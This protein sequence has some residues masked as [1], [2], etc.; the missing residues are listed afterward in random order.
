MQADAGESRQGEGEDMG[1]QEHTRIAL[2][3]TPQSYI[4]A[5]HSRAKAVAQ[6]G[7]SHPEARKHP[8]ELIQCSHACSSTGR[9]GTPVLLLWQALIIGRKCRTA[10]QVPQDAKAGKESPLSSYPACSLSKCELGCPALVLHSSQQ[11]DTSYQ[12]KHQDCSSCS[13]QPRE[14]YKGC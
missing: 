7:L 1:R 2:P 8:Q 9:V 12:H 10:H 5:Q 4:T 3:S 11:S 13:E 6:G 14:C